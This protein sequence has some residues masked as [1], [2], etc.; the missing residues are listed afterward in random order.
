MSGTILIE[1]F[2]IVCLFVVFWCGAALAIYQSVSYEWCQIKPKYKVVVIFYA[3]F[4][5]VFALNG[6]RMISL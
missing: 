5:S 3:T 2:S 4:L 1:V 6:L